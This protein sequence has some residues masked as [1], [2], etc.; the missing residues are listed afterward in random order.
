MPPYSSHADSN[1]MVVTLKDY[2]VPIKVL[3]LRMSVAAAGVGGAGD[4]AFVVGASWVCAV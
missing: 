4:D 3:V 2:W 1:G